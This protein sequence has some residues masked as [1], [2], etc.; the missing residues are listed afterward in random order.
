MRAEPSA[1]VARVLAVAAPRKLTR[2]CASTSSPGSRSSAG[3][4][5]SDAFEHGAGAETPAA[6]HRHERVLAVAAFEFVQRGGDEAR[7]R[8]ADRVAERNRTAVDVGLRKVGLH[9]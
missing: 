8:R 6:A 1:N 4:P 7:A 2:A 5:T 9:L 3:M